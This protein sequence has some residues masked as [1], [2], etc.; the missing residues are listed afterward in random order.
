MSRNRVEPRQVTE[1]DRQIG[2]KL[3]LHRQ[4][5]SMSQTALADA[6]GVTYQQVQ[7]YETASDRIPA[8]RLKRIADALGVP[9]GGFFE[10]GDVDTA[11]QIDGD[12]IGR[13]A[14]ALM[15]MTPDTREQAVAILQTMA[16]VDEQQAA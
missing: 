12:A 1:I 15:K 7:K 5:A 6:I 4:T 8:A 2:R 10:D 16:R 9:I 14:R 13:C 3:K 11:A